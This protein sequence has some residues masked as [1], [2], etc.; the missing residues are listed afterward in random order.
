[1]DIY[2]KLG[3]LDDEP[4]DEGEAAARAA[5]WHHSFDEWYLSTRLAPSEFGVLWR[6][7]YK[8][9]A[10][11]GLRH[12]ALKRS[13]EK[14]RRDPAGFGAY[15]GEFVAQLNVPADTGT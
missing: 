14:L 3:D 13:F 4:A 6:D 8:R 2:T 9:A 1:L 7:F 11:A 10:Q 5:Y 12:P 15:A